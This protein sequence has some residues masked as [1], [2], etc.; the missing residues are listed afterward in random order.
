MNEKDTIDTV[1]HFYLLEKKLIKLI[2][3]SVSD[4][5][6]FFFFFSYLCRQ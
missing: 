5:D 3:K 1:F 6:N 4:G 2:A